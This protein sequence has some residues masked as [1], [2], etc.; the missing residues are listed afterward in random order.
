V[1][2][3]VA[4][5]QELDQLEAERVAKEDDHLLVLGATEDRIRDQCKLLS[6]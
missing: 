5:E 4:H 2:Q 3:K 1:A 6:Q